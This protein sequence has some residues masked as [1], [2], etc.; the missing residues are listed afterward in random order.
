MQ[1]L[2]HLTGEPAGVVRWEAGCN[3]VGGTFEITADRLFVDEI[4]G[5]AVG[6]SA[7]QHYDDGWLAAFFRGDPKWRLTGDRLT[8]TSGETAIEL[9]EKHA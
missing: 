1:L 9:Q 7:E 5:T 4:G 3:L 2:D 8:L 6:C